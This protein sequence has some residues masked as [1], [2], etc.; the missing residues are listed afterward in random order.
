[1]KKSEEK[2]LVLCNVGGWLAMQ[3]N[4]PYRF[5]VLVFLRVLRVL[6]GSQ[7]YFKAEKIRSRI[8]SMEPTP[9]TFTYFGAPGTPLFAQLE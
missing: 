8:D 4:S 5:A 9:A 7:Y 1:M 6:R 2:S 3:P